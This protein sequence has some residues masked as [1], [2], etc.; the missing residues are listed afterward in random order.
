LTPDNGA[1]YSNRAIELDE[2][3]GEAYGFRAE[4][5]WRYENK[6]EA[7]EDLR[8]AFDYNSDSYLASANYMFNEGAELPDDIVQALKDEGYI[9]ED[10]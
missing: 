5:N 8:T 4:I 1:Y 2:S 9:D 10:D 7:L 6:D 3:D